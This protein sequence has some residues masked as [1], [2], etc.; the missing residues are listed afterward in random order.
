MKQLI[1]QTYYKHDSQ[2]VDKEVGCYLPIDELA[3]ESE[4]R[5]RIYAS[6]IGADYK[7]ISE[8][9]FRKAPQPAWARCQ[10]FFETDYDE[11]CYFDADMLPSKDCLGISIFDWE[12]HGKKTERDEGSRAEWHINMGTF[13]ISKR[14]MYACQRLVFHK[15]YLRYL[16]RFGKNQDPLNEMF[17]KGTGR[18]PKF[19]DPRWNCTRPY[20]SP[21]WIEH[22]IG[23]QKTEKGNQ[24]GKLKC[25][26][27]LEE[28]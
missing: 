17:K 12:G 4:K 1:L 10:M 7:M 23:H 13:K 27:Y 2:K 6:S 24:W 21:R 14:E 25:P 26:V 8:P 5:F 18:K 20:H 16:E 11:V 3:V 22:K 15:P 28:W 9:P 19:L